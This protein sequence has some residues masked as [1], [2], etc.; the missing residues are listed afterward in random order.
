MSRRV[1]GDDTDYRVLLL[2]FIGSLS[3]AE[4]NGEVIE[5]TDEVLRRMGYDFQWET[6]PEL[7]AWL[8]VMRVTTLFD[9]PL[10][11]DLKK[12]GDKAAHGG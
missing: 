9:T 2:K 12:R 10:G 8:A 4:T 11:M 3:L 6:W 5:A 7:Q 1:P